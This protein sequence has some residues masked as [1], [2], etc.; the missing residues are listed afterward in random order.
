LQL[1][2]NEKAMVVIAKDRKL[3]EEIAPQPAAGLLEKRQRTGEAMKLLRKCLA[4]QRPKPRAGTTAKD[5]GEEFLHGFRVCS[6][7]LGK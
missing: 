5:E 6:L 1:L 4:R 2:L 7:K 3:A